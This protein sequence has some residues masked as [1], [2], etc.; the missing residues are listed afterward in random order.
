MLSSYQVKILLMIKTSLTLLYFFRKKTT[1]V[2]QPLPPP[3]SQLDAG[4]ARVLSEALAPLLDPAL[5][6]HPAT[7]LAPPVMVL[8][9]YSNYGLSPEALSIGVYKGAVAFTG[10][11][12]PRAAMFYITW[13]SEKKNRY[14][15]SKFSDVS[16]LNGPRRPDIQQCRNMMKNV[17]D[18]GL[19]VDVRQTTIR[20]ALAQLNLVLPHWKRSRSASSYHHRDTSDFVRCG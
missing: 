6:P 14:I 17:L 11:V 9:K 18:Y 12:S 16:F 13:F 8:T 5:A 1:P 10:A 4:L 15:M 7:A 2:E 20:N 19:N 3:A